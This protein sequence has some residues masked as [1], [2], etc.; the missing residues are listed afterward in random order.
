MSVAFVLIPVLLN[1]ELFLVLDFILSDFFIDFFLDFGLE[2]CLV[3]VQDFELPFHEFHFD[4]MAHELLHFFE[5]ELFLKDLK[6]L[7]P[8]VV[9]SVKHGFL[10]FDGEGS[11]FEGGFHLFLQVVVLLEVVDFANAVLEDVIAVVCVIGLFG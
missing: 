6:L 9:R 3:Q 8:V 1:L 11:L 10:E 7:K 4:G 2:V 5:G